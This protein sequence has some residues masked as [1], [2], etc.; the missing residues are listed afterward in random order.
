MNLLI[1]LLY[2]PIVFYSLK[3]FELKTVSLIIFIFSLVWLT[4]TIKKGLKEYIFPLFYLGISLLAYFLDNFLLLKLLPLLISSLISIFILY[5]Y[6]SKQSFIFIF[7]EKI[8]K[9]VNEKEKDYIQ[10]STLFWFFVSF[11]NI[12]V[13]GYILKLDNIIYWTFYSS[14]GWY[15]LFI[16]AGLIQFLHKKIYFK[17]KIHV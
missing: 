6:I 7:L 12:L 10:K 13:H 14:I 2:A 1:S 8:N 15:L 4:L 17:E 5:S 9:K 3:N 11:I 16:V